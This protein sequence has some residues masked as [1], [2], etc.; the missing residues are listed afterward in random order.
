[1]V[2]DALFQ[3]GI[4]ETLTFVFKTAWKQ[5]GVAHS[6]MEALFVEAAVSK[7]APSTLRPHIVDGA[8][9]IG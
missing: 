4:V 9:P 7:A 2:I 5:N 1:M 8:I 6:T 3:C